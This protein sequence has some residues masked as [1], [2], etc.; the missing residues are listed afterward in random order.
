MISVIVQRAPG[1]KQG[2]DINDPLLCATQAAVERGRNE[3]DAD[4]SNRRVVA[5]TGPYRQ[6]TAPGLLIE[7]RGLRETYRGMV[8]RSALT[9]RRDGSEFTADMSLELEREA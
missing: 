1:D 7:V 9:I 2:Q 5:I 3:I 8:R 4:C 6:W